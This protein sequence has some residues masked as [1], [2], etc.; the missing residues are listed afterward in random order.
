MYA[1][2]SYYG[3]RAA[4]EQAEAANKAKSEFLSVVSHEL[5]TPLT[6]VRGFAQII[7]KQPDRDVFPLLPG[8]DAKAARAVE[9]TRENLEII[10]LESLRLTGLINDLLDFSKLESGHAEFAE[11]PVDMGQVLG[12][13]VHATESLFQETGVPLVLS[14]APDLPHVSG[15]PDRLMQVLVNLLSNAVKF[16]AKG[17][18]RCEAW[19]GSDHILVSVSDTGAR[20][21]FV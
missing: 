21:N 17:E 13:A 19:A 10:N 12:R 6:A 18:V 16:T 11:L 20:N 8:D 4:K 5:R 15:D 1:I 9:H 7:G 2:R 14:L 3:Y